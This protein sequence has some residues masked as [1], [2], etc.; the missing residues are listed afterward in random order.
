ML[1]LTILYEIH[2][3]HRFPSA[4]HLSSYARLVHVERTSAGKPVRDGKAH[5]KIGNPHLKWA[6]SEIILHAQRHSEPIQKYYERLHRKHGPGKAQSIIAHKFAVAIYY[7]L[8][9]GQAFDER[10]FVS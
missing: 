9:K 5:H 10:K 4:Q 1:A 6:F 8:K 7:M 3:I 2:T